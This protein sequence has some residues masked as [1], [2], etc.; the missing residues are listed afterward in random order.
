MAENK[1]NFKVN[2]K[3]LEIYKEY[4]TK[5]ILYPLLLTSPHSGQVFPHEFLESVK[6]TE[7]IGRFIIRPPAGSSGSCST[8]CRLWA[9]N[10]H[11]QHGR[12]YNSHIPH[13]KHSEPYPPLPR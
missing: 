7:T 1:I 3:K 13:Y 6:M 2:Y 9:G 12:R 11:R 4:N 5:N 10:P 8:L